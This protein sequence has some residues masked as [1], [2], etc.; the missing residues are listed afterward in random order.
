[1]CILLFLRRGS[2]Q[3]SAV[4]H[5]LVAHQNATSYCLPLFPL[6]GDN[7]RYANAEEKAK[8]YVDERGA[9][10]QGEITFNI[11]NIYKYNVPL[12]KSKLY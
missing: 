9:E 7:E 10:N 8:W 12:A 2:A 11:L 5:A 1:M 3:G 4:F 6:Q